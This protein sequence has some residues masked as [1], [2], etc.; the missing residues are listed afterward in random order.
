MKLVRTD[1]VRIFL[2]L[3][4]DVW[5]NLNTRVQSEYCQRLVKDRLENVA[6]PVR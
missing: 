5:T 3:V 1:V 4:C 6:V 2:S